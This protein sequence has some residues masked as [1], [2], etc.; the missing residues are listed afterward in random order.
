MLAKIVTLLLW[1]ACVVAVAVPLDSPLY[2][3]GYW[4]F[5]GLACA[6]CVEC[7]VFAPR[8]LKASSNKLYNF[9]MILV[10]GVFHAQ[11]LPK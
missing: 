4:T 11:T 8:V 10:F 1:A 2:E 5:I 9:A 6:H 7:L 3:I